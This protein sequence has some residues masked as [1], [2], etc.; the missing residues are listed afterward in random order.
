MFVFAA[1]EPN[2]WLLPGDINEV[3]WGTAAFL[4]VLAL[5]LWKGLPVVKKAMVGRSERIAAEI[6]AAEEVRT[7]AESELTTLRQ[8]LGN[9]DAEA[10]SI[11]AE[12]RTRA[13]TIK[14]DLMR[15]ADEE[16]E[17]SKV[18]A[19]IEIEAQRQQ[20]L[21]DLRAE[22][23]SQASIA[24]EAVVTDQLDADRQRR[25]IDSYIDQVGAA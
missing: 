21:A 24:T 14:A 23:A 1:E 12:A 4:V 15:R 20:A 10:E 25:L 22:I 16:V 11:L 18:R 5:F 3:Y 6:A 9:A 8:S 2:G 7:S 17:A 13:E 19:G